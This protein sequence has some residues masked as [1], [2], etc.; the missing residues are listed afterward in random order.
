MEKIEN[1]YMI[2]TMSEGML[3]AE[4]KK[5]AKI[6]LEAAKLC[7]RQR[8]ELSNRKEMPILI[9]ARELK[10][11]TK[12]ARKYFGSNEGYELLSAAAILSDSNVSSIVVNFFLK[13]NLLRTSIPVRQFVDRTNALNWLDQYK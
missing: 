10:S 3:Y 11:L 13:V 2:Q 1:D 12:E 5:D 4:Y 7:V 6:D 9:D 8:V